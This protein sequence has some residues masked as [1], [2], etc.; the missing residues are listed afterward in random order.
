MWGNYI[1][2]VKYQYWIST[3]FAFYKANKSQ[4]KVNKYDSS[5]HKIQFS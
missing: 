5:L 1:F 3:A 4:L 2:R